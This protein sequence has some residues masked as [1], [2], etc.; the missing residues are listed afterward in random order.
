MPTPTRPT[1]RT[2]TR[3]MVRRRTLTNATPPEPPVAGPS[4]RRPV[5]LVLSA[6]VL[7]GLAAW[8]AQ[9]ADQVRAAAGT[10]IAL[11]DNAA[12]SEANGQVANAVNT[13]FSY[14]Y[15]DLDKTQHAARSLLTGKAVCQYDQLF[16][17]VRQHAPRQRLVVTVTV[18]NSGVQMLTGNRAR[19][20][21]FATQSDTSTA[22]K[23]TATAGAMFAVNAVRQDGSWKVENIDTF[24]GEAR[25]SS[26]G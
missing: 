19:V 5:A 13:L 11:T 15:N 4:L 25:T 1:R 22:T 17:V 21:V 9:Q 20:L 10:N 12:T 26:C 2:F 8:F 24:N 14:R 7:S 16:A 6:V 18:T 3:R 23:Q